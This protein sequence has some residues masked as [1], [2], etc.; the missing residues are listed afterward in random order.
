MHH[1]LNDLLLMVVNF[2]SLHFNL[3]VA[4]QV[5]A[6]D[7]GYKAG[8]DAIRQS[9]P[10]VLYLLGADAGVVSRENLPKDCFIIYQGISA[11]YQDKKGYS[12]ASVVPFVSQCIHYSHFDVVVTT[13]PFC[14][15]SSNL[16]VMFTSNLAD[17]F[18]T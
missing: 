15:S 11:S 17:M 2:Q 7:I 8:I 14:E 5:A 12:N 10:K 1:G 9:P 16:A 18:S 13:Q 4:A 3:Q 6:L